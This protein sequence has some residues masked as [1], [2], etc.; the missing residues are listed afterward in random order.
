MSPHEV[1]TRLVCDWA[2]IKPS[3]RS[4]AVDVPWSYGRLRAM[5][6][7]AIHTERRRII[8]LAREYGTDSTCSLA[9]ELADELAQEEAQN[10]AP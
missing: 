2:A 4:L 1:A 9:D 5:I 3:D 7:E 6:A 8:A 10:E